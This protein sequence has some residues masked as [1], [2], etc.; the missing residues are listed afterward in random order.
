MDQPRNRE[1]ERAEQQAANDHDARVHFVDQEAG[2]RL[3]HR[4]H[5]IEGGER[6][7]ELGIG[8]P[9]V[10]AHEQEQRRKQ[11]DVVVADEMAEAD[12]ADE[13][14]LA[15]ARRRQRQ[16][17]RLGHVLV[18]SSRA[19]FLLVLVAGQPARAP[20]AARIACHTRCG[21]AG[22]SIWRMP[23]SESASTTAFM[24]EVSEPAQPASPQPFTPS[25]L[26][27]AGTSWL[28]TDI[29]GASLARGSA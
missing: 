26:V 19:V 7:T 29:I 6:K 10:L 25:G 16:I 11:H 9:V 23:Y 5:H 21:V 8:D 17:D 24:I 27:L 1:R 14:L 12:A 2:G 20:W 4:R 13:L 3:H 18:A 28:A 15:R 22:M